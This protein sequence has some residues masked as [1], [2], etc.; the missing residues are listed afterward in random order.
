MTTMGRMRR[1][2]AMTA[3]IA[4]MGMSGVVGRCAAGAA[5]NGDPS[6]CS[7]SS[8]YYARRRS[9]GSSFS[10]T[11]RPSL[12]VV[13]R[14]GGR[15][16]IVRVRRRAENGPMRS[17]RHPPS[18]CHRPLGHRR[19]VVPSAARVRRLVPP[20][21]NSIAPG[22]RRPIDDERARATTSYPPGGHHRRRH[23]RRH[24]IKIKR[25]P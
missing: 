13:P 22:S 9:F 7:H 15:R 1:T 19:I 4:R 23:R 18:R 5:S 25:W 11:H 17:K 10:S 2:V 24:R 16:S 6:S 3:T 20:R 12:V 14:W 8:Y 21:I